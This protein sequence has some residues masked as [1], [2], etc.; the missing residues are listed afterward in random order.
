[1]VISRIPG[2]APQQSSNSSQTINKPCKIQRKFRMSKDLTS[3]A[4]SFLNSSLKKTTSI[5]KISTPK[6]NYRGENITEYKI[7]QTQLG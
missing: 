3:T 4:F 6:F 5:N 1:M 7:N 2:L